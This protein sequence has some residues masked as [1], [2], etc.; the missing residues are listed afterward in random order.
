[1]AMRPAPVFNADSAYASVLQ[2]VGFG[3]RIPGT[4]P[5]EKCGDML[6]NRMART[7]ATV[8]EQTDS[9]KD[10]RG[11]RIPVRNIIASFSPEQ[12]R[13]MMLCAHWDSRQVADQDTSGQDEPIDGASDGASGVAVLLEI[14][15]L[16][17]SREAPIGVDL[18]FFDTED[19]GRPEYEP[20]PDP[21]V[22]FY[23][24]GSRY[25]GADNDGYQAEFAI[26]LDM[27][28]A[29]NAVFTMEGTSMKYAGPIVRKVWDTG[30]Q[31]GYSDYFRYNRTRA[32]TDDH[33]YVNELTGIPCID[34]IHYESETNTSFGHY[35]HTHAD[36]MG[37]I[38]RKTLKAVGQTLVQVIYNE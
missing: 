26:L 23:C 9:V 13:R 18:I 33:T 28:G 15:R 31:L 22:H 34:I 10:Y 16:L 38:D 37:I 4:G 36:N 12:S 17:S 20:D 35:W 3:P 27:V 25:W 32:L 24:L 14:G 11:Q 1:M 8:T 19:Q 29:K 7:G 6:V 2:Q 30:N 5:H 21:K